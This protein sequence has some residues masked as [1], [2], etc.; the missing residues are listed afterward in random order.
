MP[1]N[2]DAVIAAL[3]I[4]Q[5]EA[6]KNAD[7]DDYWD[8]MTANRWIDQLPGAWMG[9]WRHLKLYGTSGADVVERSQFIGHVRATLAYLEANR[10]AIQ[11]VRFWSWPFKGRAGNIAP[12]PI[13]AE[14]NEITDGRDERPERP[15]KPMRL[16][17]R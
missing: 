17:K 12:E 5:E 1:N 2:V 9:R 11:S 3:R 13:D 4:A 10:E 8:V 14:F 7:D 15:S 6:E 16:I